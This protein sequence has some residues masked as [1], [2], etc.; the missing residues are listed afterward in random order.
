M[1]PVMNKTPTPAEMAILNV[2]WQGPA[3]VR[4]VHEALADRG[5]GYTTVLKTLQI[6]H[7][8]GLVS[9]D[10][11]RRSHVYAA[12]VPQAE[13]QTGLVD[14]LVDRAFAGS[15][16]ALVMRALRDRPT[17]ADELA[18]IRALLDDLEQQP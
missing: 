15:A 9:R 13:V 16:S 10:A 4:A 6:M 2:L 3:T 1:L 17:S 14:A 7:D 5:V 8:K 11:S 18:E 12:A